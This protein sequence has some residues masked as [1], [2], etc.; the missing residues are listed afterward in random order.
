MDSVTQIVLGAAIGEAVGGRKM[1][2]K[3]A[4]WGAIAGT[5]PDLDVFISAMYHPIESTLVHRGFSHSLLFPMLFAPLFAWLTYL[6]YKRK[7]EYKTW[8]LLFFWGIITHP[9][10]DIFTNYGTSLFWPFKNRIAFNSVFVIDPLYT[11]PFMI[12]VLVAISLNKKAKWRSMI[13]WSGI[14]YSTLYLFWGLLIQQSIKNHT[15]DYFAQS[16]IKVNRSEVFAMPLTSFYWMILGEDK[17]NYYIT[18]KS[19]FG[20]YNPKDVETLPKNHELLTN[21]QWKKGQEDYP[22]LLS[23]FSKNYYS[24]QQNEDTCYYYDLRFGTA[25]KLTNGVAKNPIYGFGLIVDNNIVNKTIRFKNKGTFS[26]V[27]FGAYWNNI[28]AKNE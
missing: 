23:R 26:Y 10:L 27:N 16:N 20:K 19:I 21:L 11:I 8:C 12:T 18:Y 14:I 4:L 2:A 3:A 6:I 22:E 17:Q 24:L 5:I 13:N 28:F 15:N 25:T 7:Y 1:G 9:L